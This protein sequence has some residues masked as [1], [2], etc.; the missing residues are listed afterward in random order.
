MKLRM[1]PMPRMRL[2]ARSGWNGFEGVELFADTDEL[3]RLSG[4]VADRQ[5]RAA[6][7]IA[8]HLGEDDAGDAE[9]LV[10]LVGAL[11]G[12]L[13]GHGVGHEEDLDGIELFLE[14]LQFHHQVVVD[15]ETSG[16]VD[17]QYVAAAVGSFAARGS[18]QIERQVSPGAP[19]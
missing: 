7:R 13:P 2:A 12:V 17:Q 1:S 8:I 10:E 3:Q 14:L 16:G 4:D 15:V 6:A 11:D 19:S 5:R 9:P 18:R